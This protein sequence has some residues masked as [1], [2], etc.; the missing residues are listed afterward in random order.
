MPKAPPKVV[1]RTA[2][3]RAGGRHA[4]KTCGRTHVLPA[5]TMGHSI[6]STAGRTWKASSSTHPQVSPRAAWPHLHAGLR[7]KATLR[8]WAKRPTAGCLSALKRW[9]RPLKKNPRAAPAGGRGGRRGRPIP[10]NSCVRSVHFCCDLRVAV[11]SSRAERRQGDGW[12]AMLGAGEAAAGRK[13]A[14]QGGA[15][16][17]AIGPAAR[18]T[19][20]G[21][22]A[23][24]AQLRSL[25]LALGSC[26][27]VRHPAPV[28]ALHMPTHRLLAVGRPMNDKSRPRRYK[29]APLRHS[30]L[31]QHA[32]YA[33]AGA[34]TCSAE[35][36]QRVAS[37]RPHPHAGRPTLAPNARHMPSPL[38]PL[39]TF[40]GGCSCLS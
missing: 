31:T 21:A 39:P 3:A 19:W 18:R 32:P 29:P 14:A 40:D 10:P 6:A 35:C 28:P 17:A 30:T 1:G 20:A 25:F 33:C 7:F 38:L 26:S 37:T 34:S 27:P 11:N 12:G 16:A 15:A 5:A 4:V 22:E 8:P 24:S 23:A 36:A 2:Y 13:T 9:G